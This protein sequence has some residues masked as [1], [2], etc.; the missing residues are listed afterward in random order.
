MRY[1]ELSCESVKVINDRRIYIHESCWTSAELRIAMNTHLAELCVYRL[2]V[3]I[4]IY[5]SARL[6]VSKFSIGR[7]EK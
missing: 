1:I 4:E 6:K 3:I 5:L 7:Q 2:A